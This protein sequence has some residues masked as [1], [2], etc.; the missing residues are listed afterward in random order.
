MKV[1]I[2]MRHEGRV[3]EISKYSRRESFLKLYCFC[4]GIISKITEKTY[5]NYKKDKDNTE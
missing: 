4:D 5:S 1:L 3:E 2:S